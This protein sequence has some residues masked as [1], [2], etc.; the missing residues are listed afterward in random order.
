MPAVSSECENDD[1]NGSSVQEATTQDLEQQ[2]DAAKQSLTTWCC[3]SYSD[4][5]AAWLHICGV[6]LF[7]ESVLRYG[8]PPKFLGTVVQPVNR[9]E[10]KVRKALADA[11]AGTGAE[12]WK[13]EDGGFVEKDMFPYVSFSL[14]IDL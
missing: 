9:Q 2:L 13:A 7:V 10:S 11:Y 1:N 3:T 5:F 14:D 12:F 4:A 8:L 6:R